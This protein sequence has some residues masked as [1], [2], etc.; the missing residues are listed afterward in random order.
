LATLAGTYMVLLSSSWRTLYMRSVSCFTL[1]QQRQQGNT[2]GIKVRV[3]AQQEAVLGQ[4]A[5]QLQGR[6]AGHATRMHPTWQV[7]HE[8]AGITVQ[9]AGGAAYGHQVVQPPTPPSQPPPHAAGA[10]ASPHYG[11]LVCDLPGPS[12]R[13]GASSH[14]PSTGQANV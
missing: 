14:E 3:R 9:A 4:G 10:A 2:Q 11:P 7:G 12:A 5:A 6:C 13:A 1:W 8:A